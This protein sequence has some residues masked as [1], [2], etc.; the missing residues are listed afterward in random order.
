MRPRDNRPMQLEL[1][2]SQC[3]VWAG[4][5]NAAQWP[6]KTWERGAAKLRKLRAKP[7]GPGGQLPRVQFS[8]WGRLGSYCT[9]L[10]TAPVI[11]R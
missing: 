6:N 5:R 10:R 3:V 11:V 2:L 8:G 9:V 7:R 1:T 4:W